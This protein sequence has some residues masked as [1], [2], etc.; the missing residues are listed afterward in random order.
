MKKPWIAAFTLSVLPLL[1]SACPDL[2]SNCQIDGN[3]VGEIF[4][5]S[6]YHGAAPECQIDLTPEQLMHECRKQ[7]GTPVNRVTYP[8]GADWL[9]GWINAVYWKTYVDS[10]PK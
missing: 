3:I 6:H 8:L 10:S 4:S 5:S 2:Y 7:Y 1:G 9:F